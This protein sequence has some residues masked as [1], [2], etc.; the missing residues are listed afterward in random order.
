MLPRISG[1][2]LARKGVQI[3]MPKGHGCHA[4]YR[5]GGREGGRENRGFSL[6]LTCF[7]SAEVRAARTYVH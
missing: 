3:W 7:S 4:A 6:V 1:G 2:I 5:E